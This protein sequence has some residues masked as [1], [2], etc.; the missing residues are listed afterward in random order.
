[1]AITSVK[2]FERYA[3]LT[4]ILSGT[5][6][7]TIVSGVVSCLIETVSLEIGAFTNT[8]PTI[9]DATYPNLIR[10]P[11]HKKRSGITARHVVLSTL[12]G[13]SPLEFRVTRTVPIFDPAIFNGI[14]GLLGSNPGITYQGESNWTIS[15]I[16]N[17]SYGKVFTSLPSG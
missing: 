13:D 17:E 9:T 6:G 7:E 11:G 2:V 3:Y 8:P 10:L 1:M 15:S 5:D 4:D 14:L 12:V 16:Q